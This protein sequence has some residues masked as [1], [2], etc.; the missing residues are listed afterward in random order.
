MSLHVCSINIKES[1]GITW[2]LRDLPVYD[3]MTFSD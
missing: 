3:G 1:L 2:S